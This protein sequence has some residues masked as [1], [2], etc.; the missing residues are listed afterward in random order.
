M[1]ERGIALDIEPEDEPTT[2]SAVFYNTDMV[3][4]RDISV[5]ALAAFQGRQGSDLRVC[6]ALAASGIRGLRYLAE[7]DGIGELLLNDIKPD[8]VA[9]IRE[10]IRLNDMEDAAIQVSRK[11]ANLLLTEEFRSL[12]YVDIDPFGSPAAY[13]DSTARA[14]THEGAVGITATDLGPLYGSYPEVCRRRYGSRTVKCTV[15]HEIGLR[16]LLK[17]VFRAFARYDHAFHPLLAWHEQHYSRVVG[18]VEESKKQCNRLLEHI[19]ILSVCRSCRWRDDVYRE[20]CPHCDATTEQA[21]PLWTGRLADPKF[22]GDVEDRLAAAGYDEAEGLIGTLHAEAE[23]PTPFYATHE[24]ASA[25]GVQAP[26]KSELIQRL[27][28]QGYRATATHFS[29]QAVRTDAP[30]EAIQNAVQDR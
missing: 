19:G 5:A 14:V 23:I 7:V 22:A 26:Q 30:L 8:A 16:I 21:G 2:D 3:T 9:N 1:D 25:A 13:L 11:D 29:P 10:N 20:R 6:D 24:L 15:G 28:D 17:E 12:D 27:R 18:R 4:N